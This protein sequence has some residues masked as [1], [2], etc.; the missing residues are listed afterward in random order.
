MVAPHF[1][2]P[3]NTGS[4]TRTYQ[5]LR[6]LA[7][8]HNVSFACI[9]RG[10]VAESDVEELSR[11]CRRLV[12]IQGAPANRGRQA[13]WLLSGRPYHVNMFWSAQLQAAVQGMVE[14]EGADAV[15]CSFLY[16]ARTLPARLPAVLAV[17]VD[18]HNA[19]RITWESLRQSDPSPLVR[20]A[21]AWNYRK[22]CRYEVEQ[23][24]RF[25]VCFS[26]SEEDAAITR[27]MAPELPVHVAPNGVDVDSFRPTEGD[28][29][30]DSLLFFGT[31]NARMNADAA[32]FMVDE[33]LPLIQQKRPRARLTIVGQNPTAA[34][35]RLAQRLGVS[36]AGEVPDV[37]PYIARASVVM[38]PVRMGGGTKVKVLE[39]MSMGRPVVATSHACRG[40]DVK[41]GVDVA[42]AD[43]PGDIADRTVALLED[44][45][46]R[47]QMGSAARVT[48]ERLYSWDSIA[49]FISDEL[50][51]AV[52]HR[53]AAAGGG[54]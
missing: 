19:D 25:D 46:A 2:L 30:E 14:E 29:E 53:R 52:A 3:T 38:A 11:V 7:A 42:I 39:S 1:P 23:Y 22:T 17:A 40:L 18:Q 4:K 47:R 5:L 20:L 9:T 16:M 8:Q 13:Q 54:S 27:L 28:G 50:E 6:R 35:L 43:T 36:V 15:L 45:E 21:A 10:A 48:V 34:V 49:A 44:A 31:M 32:V 24:R 41:D 12:V 51:S 37:R 26:V 33:I